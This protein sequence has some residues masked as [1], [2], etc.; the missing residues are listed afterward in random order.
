M[1]VRPGY[2]TNLQQNLDRGDP[3][4]FVIAVCRSAYAQ[5]IGEFAF[6]SAACVLVSKHSDSLDYQFFE[7]ILHNF[8]Q[9]R[10][11]TCNVSHLR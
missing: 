1:E 4:V 10:N 7:R 11:L 2:F 6:A 9:M 8:A 3:V 5:K